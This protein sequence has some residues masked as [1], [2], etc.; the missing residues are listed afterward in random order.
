MT[1]SVSPFRLKTAFQLIINQPSV[2]FEKKTTSPRLSF[3]F[4]HLSCYKVSVVWF[5]FLPLFDFHVNG[6]RRNSFPW[7][8]F[9]LFSRKK[10]QQ[11]HKSWWSYRSQHIIFTFPQTLDISISSHIE[12]SARSS[13]PF[14]WL[15]LFSFL[16]FYLFL[17]TVYLGRLTN[18]PRSR[19]R[20]SR[21]RSPSSTRMATAPSPPRSSERWDILEIFGIFWKY[22][23]YFGN[24]WDILRVTVKGFVIWFGLWQPGSFPC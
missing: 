12:V 8:H 2:D 15:T 14:F 23:G 24:I 9:E 4:L 5:W 20:S 17:I 22:L 6:S 10:Y 1:A 16:S 21:R 7:H 18:W 19:S 13:L 11:Q 3:S